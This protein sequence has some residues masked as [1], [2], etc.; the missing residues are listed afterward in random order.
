MMSDGPQHFVVGFVGGILTGLCIPV[1][2]FGW[3]PF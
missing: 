1:A 3:W 2:F